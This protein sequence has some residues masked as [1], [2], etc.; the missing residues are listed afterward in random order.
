MITLQQNF[1]INCDRP[2]ESPLAIPFRL[3]CFGAQRF[4]FPFTFFSKIINRGKVTEYFAFFGEA[5]VVQ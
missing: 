5:V 4:V 2:E 1:C 3:A